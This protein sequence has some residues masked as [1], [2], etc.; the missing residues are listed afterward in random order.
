MFARL[1]EAGGAAV[2][3]VVDGVKLAARSGAATCSRY[4]GATVVLVTMATLRAAM[5][6]ASR[7]ASSSTPG[8]MAIG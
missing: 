4:S 7:L 8:P 1:P 6:R 2:D 5:W 3:V